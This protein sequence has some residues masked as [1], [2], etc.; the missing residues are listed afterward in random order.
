MSYDKIRVAAGNVSFHA[1][2]GGHSFHCEHY[3]DDLGGRDQCPTPGVGV[4]PEEVLGS[5]F[6]FLML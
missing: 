2:L 5:D 6:A 4:Y 1:S 3:I